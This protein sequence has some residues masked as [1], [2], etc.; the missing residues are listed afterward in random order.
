VDRAIIDKDCSIGPNAVIGEGTDMTP[1]RQ[2]PTRLNTGIT[3][4]GK[5]A[6]VPRGVRLGRNV[7]VC[8]RARAVDYRTRVVKSG[9]T[10][11]PRRESVEPRRESVEPRREAAEPGRPART[12]RPPTP[13]GGEPVAASS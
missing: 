9:A 5:R 10:I 4:I 3:L 12:P 8:P 2:E 6:V 11:S 7:M 13:P 1:N